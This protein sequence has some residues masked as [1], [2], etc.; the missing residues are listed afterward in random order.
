MQK[1][2]T[3]EYLVK[4]TKQTHIPEHLIKRYA[5]ILDFQ[6]RNYI[7]RTLTEIIDEG[8]LTK[9]NPAWENAKYE[10]GLFERQ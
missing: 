2:N 10:E 4:K 1:I 9:I 8:Y 5:S 7:P 6:N 3:H